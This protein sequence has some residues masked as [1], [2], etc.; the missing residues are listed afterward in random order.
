MQQIDVLPFEILL[1]RRFYSRRAYARGEAGKEKRNKGSRLVKYTMR[2]YEILPWDP[3]E[4]R[5]EA[6]E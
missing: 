6:A 4:N 3:V 1:P 5:R 2:G